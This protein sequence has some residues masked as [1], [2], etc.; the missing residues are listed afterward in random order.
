MIHRGRRW[1]IVRR[2][3]DFRFLRRHNR[4][5]LNLYRWR[6]NTETGEFSKTRLSDDPIEFPRIADYRVGLPYTFGYAAVL[7]HEAFDQFHS[8]A[9]RKFNMVSGEQ[10]TF[11]F[12]SNSV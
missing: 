10:E 7:H 11:S 12:D 2:C 9:V 5:A 6:L 3:L 4:F 1:R 8:R